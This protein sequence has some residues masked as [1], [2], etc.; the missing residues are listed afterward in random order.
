MLAHP[1]PPLRG[2]LGGWWGR[3]L[4]NDDEYHKFFMVV[5]CTVGKN[6]DNCHKGRG[7]KVMIEIIS[8]NDENENNH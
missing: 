7:Q 2:G 1:P 4:K 8:V 5:Y 6:D 3:G